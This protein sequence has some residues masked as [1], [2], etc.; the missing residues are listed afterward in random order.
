MV[1]PNRTRLSGTVEVDECYI[2]GEE[3][4]TRGR[5][6]TENKSL[7][8]IGVELLE[9]KKR[10]GRACVEVIPDAS[11]GSLMAFVKEKVEQ[12]SAV[13][14]DG[15]SGFASVGKSGYA[16][17]VPKKFEVA[18]PKNILPRVHMIVSLLKRGFL[19]TRQGAVREMHLRAYLDEYVFRFNRRTTARGWLFCRFL[20]YAM[21][22][23]PTTQDELLG[24]KKLWL[25]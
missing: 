25:S 18:D 2:G 7:V 3:R 12:G 9:G 5:G 22:L 20:E 17:E 23:P 1:N 11:G 16:H 21:R 8:V 14:T 24:H 4:R 19:G 15:R 6:A 10:L 13:I